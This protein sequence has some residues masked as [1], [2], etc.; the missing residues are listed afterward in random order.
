MQSSTT[1]SKNPFTRVLSE[2]FNTMLRS[3]M[4]CLPGHIESFDESNQLATVQCGIK[5]I[6]DGKGE[7]IPLID[8]VPVQFSG[9]DEW[10]FWH[11]VGEGTEGIIVFSQRAMDSWIEQ[12]GSVRPH[13]GRV[14]NESDAMFIPGIRSKPKAI[15]GFK[16]EGIG[17]SNNDGSEYIHLKPGV[18]DIAVAQINLLG[19]V[20][21]VGNLS[22][23]GEVSDGKRS[24]QHIVDTYNSHSPGA[25]GHP[26]EDMT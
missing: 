25:S 20:D 6:I 11:H 7:N 19:N 18:L 3:M 8:N 14:M 9:S 12:G 1:G 21:I 10:H 2:A 5:R 13:V 16:N 22:A 26:P 23:S 15:P 17:M 24:M 4:V